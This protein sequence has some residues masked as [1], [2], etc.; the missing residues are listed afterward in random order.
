MAENYK[1]KESGPIYETANMTSFFREMAKLEDA[2]DDNDVAMGIVCGSPGKGKTRTVGIYVMKKMNKVRYI[3]AM[4]YWNARLMVV[5]ICKELGLPTEGMHHERVEAI[6]SKLAGSGTILLFDE[7]NK[8]I[9]SKPIRE[10]LRDIHD[11]ADDT[12]IV[13]MGT[14]ELWTKA[15]RDESLWDR[16]RVKMKFENITGKDVTL[17]AQTHPA[18]KITEEVA[19]L[20][21]R[22]TTSLRPM[23]NMLVALESKCIANNYETVD[24]KT[25]RMLDI[26][27]KDD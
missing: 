6:I 7:M 27:Q 8:K 21:A 2:H 15:Q 20:I 13:L 9:G 18:I 10:T 17:F 22:Q 19:T 4:D 26:R 16:L 25:F 3:R 24:L 23:K 5:D 11:R 12:A 1:R 14:H